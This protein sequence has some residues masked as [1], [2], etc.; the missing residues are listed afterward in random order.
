MNKNPFI[1]NLNQLFVTNHQFRSI[2]FRFVKNVLIF[3][4]GFF[5]MELVL[6]QIPGIAKGVIKSLKKK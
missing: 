3:Y 1:K 2:L 4:P 5:I 6:P